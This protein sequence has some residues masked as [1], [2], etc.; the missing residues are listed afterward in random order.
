MQWE[1]LNAIHK[2][3]ENHKQTQINNRHRE[4]RDAHEQAIL[5]Q[6]YRKS[7]PAVSG[8]FKWP[9]I[10]INYLFFTQRKM[11]TLVIFS[12]GLA[13]KKKTFPQCFSIRGFFSVL[14]ASCK[15]FLLQFV[16]GSSAKDDLDYEPCY[17]HN[18]TLFSKI[19]KKNLNPIIE[20]IIV[21]HLFFQVHNVFKSKVW[22][23][24]IQ[25]KYEL[26]DQTQFI[27]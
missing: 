23:V 3:E 9:F 22:C 1:G 24:K 15:L 13:G 16:Y 26:M 12:L 27:N 10:L 2:D 14:N 17:I 19:K 20:N 6:Q 11:K 21:M 5:I 25:V 7:Q 8:C 18:E 4:K